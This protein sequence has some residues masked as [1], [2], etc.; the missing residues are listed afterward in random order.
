[1]VLWSG[2]WAEASLVEGGE[3]RIDPDAVY[4]NYDAESLRCGAIYDPVPWD[5]E[6]DPAA[7][8]TLNRF[9]SWGCQ[10]PDPYPGPDATHP[11]VVVLGNTQEDGTGDVVLF[12]LVTLDLSDATPVSRSEAREIRRD[13]ERAIRVAIEEAFQDK[14][15]T[16]DVDQSER[17]HVEVSSLMYAPLSP[18]SNERV[19]YLS[20]V[21]WVRVQSP[22]ISLGFDGYPWIESYS[23]Q[24]L[25]L[26]WLWHA[27]AQWAVVIRGRSHGNETPEQSTTARIV[28]TIGD[29]VNEASGQALRVVDG[30]LEKQPPPELLEEAASL[31]FE[32]IRSQT[33]VP[34]ILQ[35]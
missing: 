14:A 4:F 12:L 24:L 17:P 8:V 27:K 2:A 9:V 11:E 20:Q 30:R 10:N 25:G 5:S 7:E 19:V 6:P 22:E 15:L 29:L 32:K 33:R 35:Y 21:S 34:L 18:D 31:P 13:P 3:H 28:L 16:Y 1:M 23:S 26:Y